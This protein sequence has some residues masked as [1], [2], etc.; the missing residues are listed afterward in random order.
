MRAAFMLIFVVGVATGDEKPN[1]E[2]TLGELRKVE[3]AIGGE[4]TGWQIGEAD[5]EGDPAT[6][7]RFA[8]KRVAIFGERTTREWVERGVR[9]LVKA[10]R[11]EELLPEEKDLKVVGSVS[12]RPEG[13]KRALKVAVLIDT[14]KKDADAERH[15]VVTTAAPDGKYELSI[16][17]VSGLEDWAYRIVAWIDENDDGLCQPDTERTSGID[18]ARSFSHGKE[19]W[20]ANR[21]LPATTPS[22]YTCPL[23]LQPR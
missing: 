13:S 2:W 6:L 1:L 4:T 11:I 3:A 23:A 15:L 22:P 14:G 5:V 18:D 9:P 20:R 19:G 17:A 10:R 7:A 21:T 8:G 12:G 16:P